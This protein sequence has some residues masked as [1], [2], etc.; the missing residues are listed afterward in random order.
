MKKTRDDIRGEAL[1]A[2]RKWKHAGA[3]VSM[4]VGKTRLGLEHFELVMNKYKRDKGRIAR[5]LVVAPKK[6]IFKAWKEEAEKWGM[7]DLL[8]GITF[9]TYRSLTKQDLDYDA[10]YLD[11]CH[12]LKLTHDS[13]ISKFN[14]YIIGLTGTP[15]KHQN[16]ENAE[17]IRAYCPIY[18]TYLTDEAI[19]D[20]ILNDYRITVH[21]LPL[22]NQKNHKVEVKNKAGVVT[23]SWFTSEVEHY[24]Y[25]T[26]R[27]NSADIMSARQKMSIM[28]MKGMMVYK[29]KDRYAK[30]LLSQTSEKCIVFANEQKQADE[31]CPHS[32]HSN[33]KDSEINMEKFENGV[34]SKLSCV[35]QLSEGANI[36]GLKECIILHSYGNN[37]KAAQRIGRMLRLNPDDMAHIHIL[38]FKGTIDE[39]WVA[40]ALEDF[41]DSK[42]EWYDSTII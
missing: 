25:W 5:A 17:M 37:R 26:D 38:C 28:R 20:D 39:K 41:D 30:R 24:N 4:G 23:N 18:Y 42:I 1:G 33:N 3:A 36:K 29:T 22:S 8:K 14:G 19:A 16:S 6:S 31:L 15:P 40:D 10:V 7:E 2:I 34:I 21:L 13:W 12:T 9:S 27:Y 11:E 32:Y 35:L